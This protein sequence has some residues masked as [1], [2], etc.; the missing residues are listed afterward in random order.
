MLSV[1]RY[2]DYLFSATAAMS[3]HLFFVHR[4]FARQL[5]EQHLAVAREVHALI[6]HKLERWRRQATAVCK[7]AQFG[8]VST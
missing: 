7:S 2:S 3:T 5:L 8:E 6:R 4:P 1:V